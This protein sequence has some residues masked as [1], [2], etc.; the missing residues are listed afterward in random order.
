MVELAG[1]DGTTQKHWRPHCRLS[2]EWF[3]CAV[4]VMALCHH[5]MSLA[6]SAELGHGST[7]RRTP[8]IP[9]GTPADVTTPTQRRLIR[10]L[11]TS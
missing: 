9:A 7:N 8:L 10:R 6:F 4:V 1:T 3:A 11:H 5:L 2:G